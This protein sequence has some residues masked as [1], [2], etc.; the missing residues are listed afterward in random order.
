MKVD[1]EISDAIKQA[2]ASGPPRWETLLED[3]YAEAPWNL[4]EQ[5]EEL[6][7]IAGRREEEAP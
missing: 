5:R 2:E 4:R 1:Q 6:S 7:E 3:V